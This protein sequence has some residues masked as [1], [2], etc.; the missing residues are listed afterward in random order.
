MPQRPCALATPGEEAR[1]A[2]TTAVSEAA[3]T[4][5][6]TTRRDLKAAWNMDEGS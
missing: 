6:S 5:S 1:E 2:T 4:A 3:A